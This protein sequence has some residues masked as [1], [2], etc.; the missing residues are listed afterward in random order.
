MINSN[1]TRFVTL[2][3]IGLFHFNKKLLGE[4]GVNKYPKQT[5]LSRPQSRFN[6]SFPHGVTENSSK[7]K[8][9]TLINKVDFFQ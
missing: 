4:G 6:I 1:V 3:L 2:D 9:I 7:F 8:A 5:R